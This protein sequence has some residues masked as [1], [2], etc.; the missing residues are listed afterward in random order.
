MINTS[1]QSEKDM[2]RR[3]QIIVWDVTRALDE[4]AKVNT[5]GA[6]Y[7]IVARQISEFDIR[8]IKFSIPRGA[9]SFRWAREYSVL[10]NKK[11]AFTS[12]PVVLNEY[13]RRTVFTDDVA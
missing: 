10:E 7:P 4:N 5:P 3:I 9:F 12:C 11:G 1:V 8:R 6:P 2:H 13:A